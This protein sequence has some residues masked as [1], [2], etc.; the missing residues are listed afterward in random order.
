MAPCFDSIEIG[1]VGD[2]AKMRNASG[3]SDSATNVIDELL[4]KKLL[5]IKDGVEDLT[6][7]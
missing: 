1:E 6:N 5:A 2:F 7:R 4:F 3:V